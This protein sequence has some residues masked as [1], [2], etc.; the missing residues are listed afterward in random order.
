KANRVLKNAEEGRG[1]SP[2]A[3]RPPTEIIENIGAHFS[4]GLKPRPS[5]AF[6]STLLKLNGGIKPPLPIA[7]A[8]HRHTM[9]VLRCFGMQESNAHRKR[10]HR[11][12]QRGWR[13]L[14][15]GLLL[16]LASAAGASVR[17]F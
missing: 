4:A 16:M 2:A 11:Q 7:P 6:F 17:A 8:A 12:K 9:P 13:P 10:V 5:L 14:I 3:L 1:F 15:P